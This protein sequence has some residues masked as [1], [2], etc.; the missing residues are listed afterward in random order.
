MYSIYIVYGYPTA[1][2]ANLVITIK[3]KGNVYHGMNILLTS[4]TRL[5]MLNFFFSS[6]S[7]NVPLI[8]KAI[9]IRAWY[10]LFWNTLALGSS[11]TKEY[12]NN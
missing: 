8:L 2:N 7:V 4:L 9:I 11:Y 3:S 10:I 6:T 5:I 12:I 1:T